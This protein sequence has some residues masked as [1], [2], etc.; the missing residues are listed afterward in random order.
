M[1]IL[2]A[3]RNN[4][5]TNKNTFIGF[6]E[7]CQEKKPTHQIIQF[8]RYWTWGTV[9]LRAW[10]L[11]E[12]GAA[13][14]VF[15]NSFVQPSVFRVDESPEAVLNVWLLLDQY[16]CQDWKLSNRSMGKPESGVKPKI[17][18]CISLKSWVQLET[19]NNNEF[20]YK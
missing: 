10:L 20:D 16:L 15:G 18:G 7:D 8:C 1:T 5:R 13:V 4:N 17:T 3:S 6:L 14:A 19:K 12:A 11:R 2:L 9:Y